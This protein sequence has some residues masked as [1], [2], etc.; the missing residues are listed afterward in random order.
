MF[1]ISG[2]DPAVVPAV[3]LVDDEPSV[4]SSLKRLLRSTG[5]Q[6][7]T[8]ESGALALDLLASTRSI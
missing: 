6:V 7:L 8:A 4:L 2:E 1:D 5:Y 3:L